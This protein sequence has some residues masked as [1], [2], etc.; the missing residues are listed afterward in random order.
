MA[1]HDRRYRRYTGPLTAEPT[2]FL[3]LARYCLREIFRP[4]G[5]MALFTTSLMFP[6][7]CAALI[8]VEHNLSLMTRLPVDLAAMIPIDARF[9]ETFLW[10]QTAMAFLMTLVIV[11]G[12]VAPDLVNGALPL[13]L[14]HPLTRTGYLAGK[15]ASLVA[16]LSAITWIPGS[17]L[18]LLEGSLAGRAW[19]LGSSRLLFGVVAGSFTAI[20]AFALPALAIAIH[21]RSKSRGRT[22]LVFLAFVAGAAGKI[23]NDVLEVTWGDVLMAPRVLE[24]V[25]ANALG[26][27]A[28]ASLTLPGALAAIGTVCVLSI[29]VIARRLRAYEV[30]A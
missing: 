22:A 28:Y 11:P 6:L 20:V 29:A 18:F 15:A 7:A 27:E 30:V 13:Y 5:F 17:L 1:V 8:Y 24:T 2:R 3:V 10:V 21:Y 12:I 9:F 23:A 14:S 16:L 26:G 4:R 25:Y 19:L